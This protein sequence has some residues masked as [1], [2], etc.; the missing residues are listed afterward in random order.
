M[1]TER[2]TRCSLSSRVITVIS[3]LGIISVFAYDWSVSPKLNYLHAAETHG[4]ISE[5]IERKIRSLENKLQIKK[6]N[7]QRLSEN[8]SKVEARFLTN[9]QYSESIELVQ[10]VAADLGCRLESLIFLNDLQLSPDKKM[11]I[12]LSITK[13]RAI[14][15]LNTDYSSLVSF[16]K[17][18]SRISSIDIQDLSIQS[19]ENTGIL[20]CKIKIICY[21]KNL[22]PSS[23]M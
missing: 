11:D 12:N 14:I 6:K 15:E 5:N 7:V 16:M 23:E 13:K 19:G 22:Q 10:S 17:K 21:R 2:L 1:L 8:I 3:I 9:K 4:N 20:K 18:F